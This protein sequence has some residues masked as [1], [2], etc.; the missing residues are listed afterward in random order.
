M[1]LFPRKKRFRFRKFEPPEPRPALPIETLIDE[2]LLIVTTGIRMAVKNQAILWVLRDGEDFDVDKYLQSTRDLVL[3]ASAEATADANRI[4][5]MPEVEDW[6]DE[7]VARAR[8]IDPDRRERRQNM[9]RGMSA[10]LDALAD[11]EAFL[12]GLALEARDAA[13]EE[14]GGAVT[15]NALRSFPEAPHVRGEEHDRALALV[16]FDLEDLERERLSY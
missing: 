9:L 13:W 8:A 14:I 12:A 15:A 10:R 6:E 4:E 5:A 3:A 11:D 2:G 16:R 7:S 1:R